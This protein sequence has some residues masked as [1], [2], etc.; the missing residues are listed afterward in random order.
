MASFQQIFGQL[1]VVLLQMSVGKR[2]TLMSLIL[3]TVVG[4]VFLILWS[5]RVDYQSLYTNL[6]PEDASAIIEKLKEQKIPYQ[7]TDSGRALLVPQE[8]LYEIRM[9]MASDGLPQLG[10]IGFEVFDDTKL[11]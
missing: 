3:G 2:I 8:Q 11:G 9:Q 10:G 6:D 7:I 4:F 5:G 1:R